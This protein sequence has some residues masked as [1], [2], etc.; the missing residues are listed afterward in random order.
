MLEEIWICFDS[1][2][3]SQVMLNECVG[4][5]LGLAP[6]WQ[7]EPVEYVHSHLSFHLTSSRF[8]PPPPTPQSPFLLDICCSTRPVLPLHLLTTP[9]P[10]GYFSTAFQTLVACFDTYEGLHFK[11]R[12]AVLMFS[13]VCSVRCRCG[14]GK[15]NRKK[16][17]HSENS[18]GEAFVD[19]FTI[20]PKWLDHAES[21]LVTPGSFTSG[22]EK[23]PL[24]S[25][26]PLRFPSEVFSHE[27]CSAYHPI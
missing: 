10:F 15:L 12:R 5:L 17:F 26:T 16:H 20:S 22:G 13:C 11:M 25:Q 21:H 24:S 7:W 27:T 3:N 6:R 14:T 23:L 2:R 18:S 8:G 19:S 1:S 4:C 9:L